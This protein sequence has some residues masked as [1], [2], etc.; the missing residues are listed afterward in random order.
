MLGSLI[1]VKESD[2]SSSS[3]ELIMVV[4]MNISRRRDRAAT[5]KAA[6][7]ANADATCVACATSSRPELTPWMQHSIG[8]SV[9]TRL[10]S[11]PVPPTRN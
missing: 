8:C 9:R 3:I 4:P 1:V 7:Y 11:R 5:R 2:R 6:A 10:L